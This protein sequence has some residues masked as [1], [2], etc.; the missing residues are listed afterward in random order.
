MEGGS[1]YWLMLGRTLCWEIGVRFIAVFGGLDMSSRCVSVCYVGVNGKMDRLV[2][3][4][5]REANAT[6]RSR[7]ADFRQTRSAITKQS[8][9]SDRA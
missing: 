4:D 3:V 2:R 5:D 9:S 1:A 7:Q 6:S 8:P